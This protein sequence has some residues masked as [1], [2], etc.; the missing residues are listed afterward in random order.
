MSWK[1][2]MCLCSIWLGLFFKKRIQKENNYGINE[3]RNNVLAAHLV[4]IFHCDGQLQRITACLVTIYVRAKED[5]SKF[6]SLDCWISPTHQNIQVMGF[7]LK[8]NSFCHFKTTMLLTL[9]LNPN[10]EQGQKGQI[11]AQQLHPS[12]LHSGR[13]KQ[14]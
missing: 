1:S 11:I 4:S 5:I 2:N 13:Q 7:I 12:M 9:I 10:A 14:V 3:Q 8:E 6:S